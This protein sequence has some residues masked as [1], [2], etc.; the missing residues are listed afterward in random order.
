MLDMPDKSVNW[1][2]YFIGCMLSIVK[3]SDD[4]KGFEVLPRAVGGRKNACKGKGRY[5]R[6]SKDYEYLTDTS[7]AMIYAAMTHLMKHGE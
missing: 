2:R 5:R 7:E 6:L 3:H 1:V 4:T